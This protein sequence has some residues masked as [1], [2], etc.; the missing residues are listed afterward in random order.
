MTA[1][2][3]SGH[4]VEGEHRL[5]V[6]VYFEDTDAG[7]VVYHATYLRFAER[8]RTELLRLLGVEQAA[9][10][11]THAVLF[12]VQQCTMTFHRPAFLDE[13]LTVR[14]RRLHQTRASLTLR[15]LI[16]PAGEPPRVT[17]DVRVVAVDAGQGR[18]VRIPAE[19]GA[20][21]TQSLDEISE[22]SWATT[23]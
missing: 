23:G 6:R 16:A 9:L 7:G 1:A 2:E 20:R 18:P 21:L 8:A 5:P 13:L 4:L 22:E 19:L 10:K 17:L 14:T 11:R 12:L 15:Q 3:L